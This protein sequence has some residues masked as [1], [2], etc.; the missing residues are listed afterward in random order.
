MGHYVFFP[1]LQ[2]FMYA[3]NTFLYGTIYVL[4]RVVGGERV[5]VEYITMP[6]K[7]PK[8]S[9]LTYDGF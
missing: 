8:L 3:D 9:F 7:A 5:R 6:W 2:I 4:K 1:L